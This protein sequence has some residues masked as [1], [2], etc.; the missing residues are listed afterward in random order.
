MTVIESLSDDLLP[1]YRLE[2]GFG[3]EVARIDEPAGRAC[4]L[5]VIF[6]E[7][8]HVD[9]IASAVTLPPSVTYWESRDGHYPMEAGYAC[10]KTGHAVAAPLRVKNC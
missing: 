9:E 2:I 1:I 7:P 10:A 6:R 5:A 3:N 8:L 4:P